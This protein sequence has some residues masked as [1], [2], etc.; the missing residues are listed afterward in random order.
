MA[1]PFAKLLRCVKLLAQEHLYKIL[2]PPPSTKGNGN[3]G[4]KTTAKEP[5]DTG[6]TVREPEEGPVVPKANPTAKAKNKSKRQ[7]N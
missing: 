2:A 6:D 3:K 5:E 4:T 7:K 1:S